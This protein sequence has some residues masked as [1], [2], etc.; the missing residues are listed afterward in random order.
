M[1]DV[2]GFN[3]KFYF[4]FISSERDERR[5]QQR[6]NPK[7]NVTVNINATNIFNRYDEDYDDYRLV[8]M[9]TINFFFTL[10]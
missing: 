5:L 9:N 4:I 10:Q 3:I 1:P 6:T 8:F 7:G 2:Q